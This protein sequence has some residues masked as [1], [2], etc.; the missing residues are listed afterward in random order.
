MAPEFDAAEARAFAHEL[1]CV[2]NALRGLD[3]L[4]ASASTSAVHSD[5]LA[6][7]V[8]CIAVRADRLR[9]RWPG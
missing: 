4:L 8:D 5:E 1:G 3:L 9:A 2:C 7:L 6:A